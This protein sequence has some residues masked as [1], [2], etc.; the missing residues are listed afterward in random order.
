MMP[1]KV[2][3]D[4]TMNEASKWRFALA[5]RMA[6]SYA[7]NPK[8]KVVM[9]AGSVGHGRAD[10]YSDIEVDVYYSEPPTTA[11]RL[12][13]VTG[14]G[15]TIESLGEDDEEW[16]EHMLI[17]GVHVATMERYLTL[18]VD[19]CQVAPS[20]QTRLYSVQH[21]VPLQATEQVELWRAKAATYPK[22]LTYEMLRE[23]LRFEGFGY[24][25]EMLAARDDLL[26][27]YSD[28]VQIER[29]ILGALLGLN[30]IYLPTPEH[31]KW[32]D[33]LIEAMSIKPAD[34]SARLKRAFH[35][36]PVAGV[37][38]L[39]EIIAETL[40]L[41]ERHVPEFD[42]TPY[43]SNLGQQRQAWDAPP[44]E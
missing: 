43:R 27:L 32:M 3:L 25:E 39:K 40:T 18:V 29:Q 38:L 28:F 35:I 41:V 20:A 13:A 2:R 9:V 31:M 42:T 8:T 4:L 17:D 11:E 36:E 37:R 30:R 34:L 33:E 24:G 16:E 12:A 6:A 15:G 26:L 5:E 7:R 23:N 44:L 21:A 22:G 14:C 19:R 1:E 10:R